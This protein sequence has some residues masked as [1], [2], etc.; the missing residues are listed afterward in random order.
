MLSNWWREATAPYD[1][2]TLFTPRWHPPETCVVQIGAGAVYVKVFI[3]GGGKGGMQINV[4]GETDTV[5]RR[6]VY[7]SSTGSQNER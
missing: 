6:N 7:I 3:T 4:V 5:H 2:I 1:P